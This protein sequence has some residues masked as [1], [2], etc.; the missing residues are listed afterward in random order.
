MN[1]EGISLVSLF[2]QCLFAV[3]LKA[4][5]TSLFSQ[6]RTG[7]WRWKHACEASGRSQEKQPICAT[8][9]LIMDEGWVKP[10]LS[11]FPSPQP[12]R[13]S[14][15]PGPRPSLRLPLPLRVWQGS[16]AALL[17]PQTICQH[18]FRK[19]TFFFFFFLPSPFSSLPAHKTTKTPWMSLLAKGARL[20]LLFSAV[21]CL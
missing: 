6:K 9:R 16:L 13:D 1:F 4:G 10:N 11:I 19:A 17:P 14:R 8:C 18:R 3:W 12:C 7:T 15:K 2:Q 5:H 21:C 20:V